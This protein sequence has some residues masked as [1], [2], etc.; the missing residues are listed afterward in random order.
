MF[1]VIKTERV[2]VWS[3]YVSPMGEIAR[4]HITIEV[5]TKVK[6][7]AAKGTKLQQVTP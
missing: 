7:G 5:G 6:T 3:G 4:M 1:G 2:W